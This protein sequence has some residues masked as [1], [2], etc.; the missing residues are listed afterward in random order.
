[1]LRDLKS[2][3]GFLL[4]GAICAYFFAP[5]GS[6]SLVGIWNYHCGV[7]MSANQEKTKHQFDDQARS[8][9]FM[10][11]GKSAFILGGTGEIGKLLLR[12][13]LQFKAFDKVTA[14]VRKPIEYD[15]PN[16]DILKQE[17]ID[18]DNIEA[19]KEAF[20]GHSVGFC[21]LGTTRGKAGKEGFIKVDHDYVVSAG[22]LAKE[23]GCEHF[24]LVSSAGSN[25]NSWFLYPKTKG[26]TEEDLA[27]LQFKRFSIFKPAFLVCDRVE[28]RT[29]EKI[30]LNTLVPVGNVLCPGKVSVPTSFVARAMFRN[31]IS[32][33]QDS[34]KCDKLTSTNDK[35]EEA[36]VEVI[37]NK[38]ILEMG[39]FEE[40]QGEKK[41]T[42]A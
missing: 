3:V 28:K 21:C 40:N 27:A 13:L 10:K 19:S 33:P 8:A 42:S 34:F 35:K 37:D 17:V 30:L 31:A 1:M 22:K 23:T 18:F 2:F 12:D 41:D 9:E 39:M 11:S 6:S 24:S 32:S 25:K 16:A 15:G 4:V 5:E 29:G 20:R 38:P 26:Q 14:F 36:L 7:N